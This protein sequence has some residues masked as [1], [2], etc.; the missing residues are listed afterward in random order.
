MQ[1]EGILPKYFHKQSKRITQTSSG[2]LLLRLVGTGPHPLSGAPC[3]LCEGSRSTI[4]HLDSVHSVPPQ[5][6]ARH[7]CTVEPSLVDTN[8]PYSHKLLT[9]N[10]YV[11]CPPNFAFA[12]SIYLFHPPIFEKILMRIRILASI[13][14]NPLLVDANG[15]YRSVQYN[16]VDRLL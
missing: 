1:E 16:E 13:R 2:L 3:G 15:T 14:W 5:A 6:K 10:N 8:R 4:I 7:S 9:I 11:N 12:R